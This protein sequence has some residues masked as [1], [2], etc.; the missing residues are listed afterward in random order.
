[1]P[2]S[3]VTDGPKA[4]KI[5]SKKGNHTMTP[6]ARKKKIMLDKV[7]RF[8]RLHSFRTVRESDRIKIYIPMSNRDYDL[9]EYATDLKTARIALGY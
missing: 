3:G 8:V 5:Q 7:E 9:I 6:Q 2:V 4:G 1:L